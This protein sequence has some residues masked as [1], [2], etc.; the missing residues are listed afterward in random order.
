[1]SQTPS[2]R[3]RHVDIGGRR[4]R[5]VEAG[6][7][8]GPLA[9]LEHGAFGCASDWACVQDRLA[10]QGVRSLAYDRAGLGWSDP[11]PLPRDARAMGR[12]LVA[13]LGAVGEAG[14]VMLAGHSMGGL[15]SRLFAIDNPARVIGL[16]LVDAVTPDVT[17]SPAG[18]RIVRAYSRAMGLVAA[19]A[20]FGLMR[21]FAALMGDMIGLPAEASREKRR[22][23]GSGAHARWSA[24]E[25]AA[26]SASAEQAGAR[27]LPPDLPV[28]VVT[29]GAEDRM[30]GLKK[31]Q[32]APG[33][34]SRFGHVEHVPGARH[35]SLLGRHYADAV[36]R[37]ICH[38]NR[39]GSLTPARS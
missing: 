25:V 32:S 11:G 24:A 7:A 5:V 6:P 3:G 31:M 33:L 10:A 16:V 27:D 36:V 28:A 8:S 15:T 2:F 12:D 39:A 19:G 1:M 20:G 38:V 22:I 17:S 23:Y 21:P 29:A 18:A 13:L 37:G 4:L 14:P 9:V 34:A 26:W 35:A 30:P